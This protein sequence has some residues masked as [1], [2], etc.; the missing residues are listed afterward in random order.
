MLVSVVE[1]GIDADSKLR[2]A[3]WR[4]CGR[5]VRLVFT[6]VDVS[7]SGKLR[8]CRVIWTRVRGMRRVRIMLRSVLWRRVSR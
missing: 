3:V 2:Y 6:P 4:R 5:S 7:S 8:T 1:S